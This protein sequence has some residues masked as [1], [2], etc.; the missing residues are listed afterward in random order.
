MASRAADTPTCDR[1]KL[2][3]LAGKNVFVAGHR[4]L[5]GA[6]IVKRLAAAA[7][8]V[9][10][11]PRS[12]VDLERQDQTHAFLHD[13]KPDVVI[14]AA[15]K[16]GG[17]KANSTYPADFI[18]GNIAIAHNVIHGSFTA[19]VEKLLFLASS[20][21][22][23]RAAPQPMQEDMLLSGP[24]EPTNEWYAVAKIAGLKLAQAYRRQHGADFVSVIPT[25]LY[26]PGDRYDLENGHVV[27]AM[28]RRFH[29][30]KGRRDQEV[31][32]WGSGTPQREFMFVDD[33]AD[34]CVFTLENYSDESP[35]NIGSGAEMSIA[36]L[37]RLVASVVGYDGRITFDTSKPDGVARKLLDGS[38][39]MSRG[40][41]AATSMQDGLRRTYDAYLAD[42]PL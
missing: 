10:T 8:R 29:E 32:V 30:A 18:S 27:A 25:N 34:A 36:D 2:F 7:C 22:Y 39:L 5:A 24:L 16:V 41:R 14:L 3:D 6:A 15:A 9:I 21:M 37:A 20:C 17:I 40:W 38:R 28:I 35:V 19:G 13:V 1:G 42:Q 26:G 33:F 11:A 23:P 31:A 12:E 4:G